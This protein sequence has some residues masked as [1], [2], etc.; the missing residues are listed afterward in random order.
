MYYRPGRISQKFSQKIE[1][2]DIDSAQ[3]RLESY[4]HRFKD[5]ESEE[6]NGKETIKTQQQPFNEVLGLFALM[7]EDK[8]V[9]N[10]A[11]LHKFYDENP[12]IKETIERIKEN[13]NCYEGKKIINYFSNTV[14]L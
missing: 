7:V 8:I 1:E 3:I 4:L 12:R 5:K 6:K 13:S 10:N 9:S 2:K 11:P 14:Y